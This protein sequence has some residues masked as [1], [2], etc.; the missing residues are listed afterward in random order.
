MVRMLRRGAWED[1]ACVSMA[2]ALA[3]GAGN[4]G[5]RWVTGRKHISAAERHPE[6]ITPDRSGAGSAGPIET[7]GS[8]LPRSLR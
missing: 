1:P 3:V 4:R 7:D 6:I 5:N 2:N 8:R